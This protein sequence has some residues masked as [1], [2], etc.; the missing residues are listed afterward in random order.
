MG[1][2]LWRWRLHL[3]RRLCSQRSGEHEIHYKWKSAKRWE[4]RSHCDSGAMN[5]FPLL[6]YVK[7]NNNKIKRNLW[8]MYVKIN[9]SKQTI[10]ICLLLYN[11]NTCSHSSCSQNQS[12]FWHC[13]GE[14]RGGVPSARPL[15]VQILSFAETFFTLCSKF[16]LWFMQGITWRRSIYNIC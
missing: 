5:L 2:C 12:T 8:P 9:F 1:F 4:M 3:L 13:I 7:Y 15:R 10:E 14:S 11:L 6:L 16:F